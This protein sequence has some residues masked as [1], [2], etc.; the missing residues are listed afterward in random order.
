MS[1]VSWSSTGGQV[2]GRQR[3]GYTKGGGGVVCFF[4]FCG[5]IDLRASLA[6]KL[7]EYRRRGRII[8]LCTKAEFAVLGVDF[9]GEKRFARC[10]PEGGERAGT[11]IGLELWKLTHLPG[12]EFVYHPALALFGREHALGNP[13]R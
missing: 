1:G 7:H 4:F 8:C 13:Q 11:E 6:N 2:Y 9:V 12:R 3:G 5:G 10:L